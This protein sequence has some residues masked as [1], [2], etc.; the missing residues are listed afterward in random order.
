M[1]TK[2]INHMISYSVITSDP[3]LTYSSVLDTIRLHPVTAGPHADSTFV[4]WSANFSSDAN[5]GEW[6]RSS[7]PTCF[8]CP[9][10]ILTLPGVIS[11]AKYKRIEALLD[12]EKAVTKA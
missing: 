12:L 10:M 7:L 4:E 9:Y 2:T 6:T 5:A 8:C 3:E 11:D 1:F